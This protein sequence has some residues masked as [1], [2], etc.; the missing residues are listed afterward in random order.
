MKELIKKTSPYT[1]SKSI[2]KLIKEN[3][4]KFKAI[5]SL[6][7]FFEFLFDG[8]NNIYG[9]KA[10]NNIRTFLTQI[11]TVDKLTISDVILFIT[12]NVE[13]ENRVREREIGCGF[14]KKFNT[15]TSMIVDN[16]DFEEIVSEFDISNYVRYVPTSIDLVYKIF[17]LLKETDIV[18]EN[19]TF[20]DVGSGIGR[21]LLIASEYPFNKIIGI[22]ISRKL[23]D[24]AEKN[25]IQ[26]KNKIQKCRNIESICINILDFVFTDKN[27]LIL[28][29]Y[30]P[31]S[32][33]VFDVLF[34]K[35]LNSISQKECKF[36]LMFLNVLYNRIEKTAFFKK[37]KSF[38]S[39]YDNFS[40]Y[41]SCVN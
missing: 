12:K 8:L 26:Y 3:P 1:I 13:F 11:A 19:S 22:E 33:K 7:E 41:V 25:I 2:L 24:I 37:E 34:E 10:L 15:T 4:A 36:T 5:Q 32:E 30:N 38:Q 23:H 17:S 21:N 39:K 29:F 14:D 20:I 6:D 27:N 16:F 35:I 28:Y 40:I 31:F 18:F 9:E